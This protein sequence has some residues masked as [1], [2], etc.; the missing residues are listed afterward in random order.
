MI[1]RG[2]G[3]ASAIFWYKIEGWDT[4]TG[5]PAQKTFEDL[6]L[7]NVADALQAENRMGSA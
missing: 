5:P 2:Y 7:N 3:I 4:A 6:G 1:G